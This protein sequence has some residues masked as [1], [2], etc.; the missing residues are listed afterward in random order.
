MNVTDR[1]AP[2]SDPG[3]AGSGDD[4]VDS[5]ADDVG[6]D[7]DDGLSPDELAGVLELFGAL[8][9][10]EFEQAVGETAFRAGRDVDTEA[11]E[12]RIDA[13]TASFHLVRVDPDAVPDVVPALDADAAA[14]VPGPR[15]W[16]E[17]PEYAEDLPHILDLDPRAVDR[18]ALAR[19]VRQQLR[20]GIERAAAQGDA[21]R[22]HEIVDVT[23]D[24][25]AWASIDLA[26]TRGLAD[27][28][29]DSLED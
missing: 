20:T 28:A 2:G 6:A 15:A 27:G 16:P 24:V 19:R 23:Y 26:D 18:A 1:D 4:D 29:L 5:G 13:A 10:D 22:L 17:E 9:D 11:L 21:D 3:G 25:E 8:T 12:A 7:G 14:Y